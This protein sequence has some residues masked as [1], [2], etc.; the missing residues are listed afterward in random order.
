ML[1][2]WTILI[3]IS[4]G[5]SVGACSGIKCAIPDYIPKFCGDKPVVR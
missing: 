4:L 5:S 1:K 2:F 3:A